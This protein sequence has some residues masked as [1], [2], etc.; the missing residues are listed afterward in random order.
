[1]KII[2]R[3]HSAVRVGEGGGVFC[4]YVVH[5]CRHGRTGGI[6]IIEKTLFAPMQSNDSAVNVTIPGMTLIQCR[7]AYHSPFASSGGAMM[8]IASSCK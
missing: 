6:R 8:L 5:V 2:K 4:T 1:M 3:E 7:L